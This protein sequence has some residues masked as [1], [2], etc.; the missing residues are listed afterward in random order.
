MNGEINFAINI[1]LIAILAWVSSK[2]ITYLTNYTCNKVNSL[3]WK[4]TQ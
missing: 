3:L 4:Q 1:V 2:T